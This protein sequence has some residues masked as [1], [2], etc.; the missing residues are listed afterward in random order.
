MIK[1]LIKILRKSRVDKIL[2]KLTVS[3]N[4]GKLGV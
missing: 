1:K 2:E 3:K 4:L